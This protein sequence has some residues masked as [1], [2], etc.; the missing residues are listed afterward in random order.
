MSCDHNRCTSKKDDTQSTVGELKHDDNNSIE[1]D[2]ANQSQALLFP[3]ARCEWAAYASR[4][5]LSHRM[6][7]ICANLQ[8]LL[9]VPSNI[10]QCDDECNSQFSCSDCIGFLQQDEGE[11]DN[12]KIDD[13]DDE[14]SICDSIR[15]TI[16]RRLKES[17]R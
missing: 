4:A 2:N 12:D 14:D 15:V 7:T 17:T 6:D 1:T 10:G 9:D 11:R 16:R 8:H 3:D 13:D 5:E